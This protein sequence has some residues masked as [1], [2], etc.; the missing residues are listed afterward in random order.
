MCRTGGQGWTPRGLRGAWKAQRNAAAKPFCAFAATLRHRASLRSSRH[1]FAAVYSAPGASPLALLGAA[2][3]GVVGR[4]ASY[5]CFAH[6]PADTLSCAIPAALKPGVTVPGHPRNA[7]VTP[8]CRR[9]PQCCSP[10]CR[11]SLHATHPASR[12][13]PVICQRGK[14]RST[15]TS[16]DLRNPLLRSN[17]G[18]PSLAT[19]PTHALDTVFRSLRK[20]NTWWAPRRC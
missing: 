2:H 16:I 13:R 15:Y 14:S 19:R 3:S 4:C 20:I 18:W 8:M 12:R 17:P 5:S 9:S 10:L 7:C 11:R 6:G 1:R